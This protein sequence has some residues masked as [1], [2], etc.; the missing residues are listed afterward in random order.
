[1][2]LNSAHPIPS[3]HPGMAVCVLFIFFPH[4]PP[5]RLSSCILLLLS[6]RLIA[7]L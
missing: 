5:P 3:A 1:L 6:Y 4:P 2:Q 7:Q